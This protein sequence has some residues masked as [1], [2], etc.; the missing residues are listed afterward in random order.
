MNR[1]VE[2]GFRG[3]QSDTDASLVRETRRFL[4]RCPDAHLSDVA[5][6][7]GVTLYEAGALALA[8][9]E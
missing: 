8:A 9:T 5:R 4:Q 1:T 7:L 3:I 6:E 2:S